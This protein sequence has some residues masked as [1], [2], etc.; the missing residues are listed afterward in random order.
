MEC[1]EFTGT[2]DA[3]GYGVKKIGGKMYKAHRLAYGLDNIP[4]GMFVCHKCDNRA[5]INPEHLFLGTP[6]DNSR[7][8][9]AKGR[10]RLVKKTHCL[11]GHE[12]NEQNTYT[13]ADNRRQC[14]VC[15]RRY[16]KGS[17]HE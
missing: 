17:N 12:Y 15:L 14:R 16:K 2:I 7:D 5:C 4:E 11:R 8:M 9:V 13:R 1:I 3:D 10:G 6:A